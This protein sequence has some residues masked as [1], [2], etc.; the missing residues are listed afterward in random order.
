MKTNHYDI[1]NEEENS[2]GSDSEGLGESDESD[3]S[4]RR[5]GLPK[6]AVTMGTK[7]GKT[8]AT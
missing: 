2:D 6:L 8:E 3:G 1:G 7:G 5:L 4:R